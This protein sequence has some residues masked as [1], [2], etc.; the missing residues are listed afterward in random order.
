LQP[1]RLANSLRSIYI[2]SVNCLFFVIGRRTQTEAY[3]I[4]RGWTFEL[5]LGPQSTKSASLLVGRCKSE[6]VVWNHSP[7]GLT[8]KSIF[9]HLRHRPLLPRTTNTQWQANPARSE[10]DSHTH[11]HLAP[12]SSSISLPVHSNGILVS[13]TTNL[14]SAKVTRRLSLTTTRNRLDLRDILTSFW[15]IKYK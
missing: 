11:T 14:P 9:L 8:C 3:A 2:H 10:I 5:P 12:I 13:A 7:S 4:T 1:R 6:R 15:P